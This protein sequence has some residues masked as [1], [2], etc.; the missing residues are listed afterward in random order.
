MEGTAQSGGNQAAAAGGAAGSQNIP[1]TQGPGQGQQPT[2]AAEA[3]ITVNG[4]VFKASDVEGILTAK[5][6]L[7]KTNAEQKAR[8]DEVEKGKLSEV[9]KAQAE[10]KTAKEKAATLSKRLIDS[11]VQ[12][13][14]DKAGIKLKAELLNLNIASEDEALEKVQKFIKDNPALVTAGGA[15]AEGAGAVNTAGVP[16]SSGPGSPGSSAAGTDREKQIQAMFDNAKS[17]ADLA[18]AQ[19]ALDE[20]RGGGGGGA[21]AIL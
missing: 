11:T 17:E 16:G 3:T 15:P 21:R 10:A 14:L 12:A 2:G 19:K 9:E 18:A 4:N 6:G 13:A 20:F 1:A 5:R 8:L 7:E